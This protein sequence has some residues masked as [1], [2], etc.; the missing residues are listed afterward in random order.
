[1]LCLPFKQTLKKDNKDV[2]IIVHMHEHSNKGVHS[3][4]LLNNI[5][6][7]LCCTPAWP[8]CNN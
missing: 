6:T 8:N 1:M 2:N 5:N 3:E 4:V 7:G